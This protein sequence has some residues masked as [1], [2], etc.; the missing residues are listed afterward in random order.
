MATKDTTPC[1]RASLNPSPPG[2][3]EESLAVA[4]VYNPREKIALPFKLSR[5]SSTGNRPSAMEVAQAFKEIPQEKEEGMLHTTLTS[6]PEP[7]HRVLQPKFRGPLSQSQAEK[8][9]STY[10]KYSAITLPPLQEEATPTSSPA[11]TL[12]DAP[13]PLGDRRQ[14]TGPSETNKKS[15]ISEDVGPP[16]AADR[17]DLPE[18]GKPSVMTDEGGDFHVELEGGQIADL[19]KPR[20]PPQ[21]SD[22]IRT[23]S[24]E[25]FSIVGNA[26]NV[27]SNSGGIFYD[28]EILAIVHRVK[29]KA[30][31]LASTIVWCWLGKQTRLGDHEDKKLQEISRRYGTKAVCAFPRVL[32]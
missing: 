27:M 30:S 2:P 23:I 18:D 3:L 22:D 31:G 24:V 16:I 1:D 9:K 29:S 20:P 17:D 7:N 19:L 25:L 13:E 5:T 15:A 6:I 26:A 14:Q 4:D 12:K 32:N 10:E 8:R 11:G 21:Q 28:S